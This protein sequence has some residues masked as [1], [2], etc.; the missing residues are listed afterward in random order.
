MHSYAETLHI[1]NTQINKLLSTLTNLKF[2]YSIWLD[3]C[4]FTTIPTVLYAITSLT[5]LI[6]QTL[7][8]LNEILSPDIGNLVNLQ[9]LLLNGNS[10]LNGN[11]PVEVGKLTKLQAFYLYKTLVEGNIPTKVGELTSM[12]D[13]QLQQI[14][15]GGPM[16]LEMGMMKNLG[17]FFLSFFLC[18][19]L[20]FF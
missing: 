8:Q 14:F 12:V 2:L 11:I 6:M 4:P 19:F 20:L 18:V 5:Y 13:L 7:S 17:R 16:P 9:T 10:F 3:S 15:L 1:H